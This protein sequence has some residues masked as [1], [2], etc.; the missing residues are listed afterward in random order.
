MQAT[1]N[2]LKAVY[3]SKATQ[4]K[5]QK[6]IVAAVCEPKGAQESNR[7]KTNKTNNWNANASTTKSENDKKKSNNKWNLPNVRE[8]GKDNER[9]TEPEPFAGYN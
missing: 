8:K 3:D 5:W 1:M 6:N 2:A 4:L 7:W 9:P